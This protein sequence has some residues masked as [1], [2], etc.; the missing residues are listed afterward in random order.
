MSSTYSI[1]LIRPYLPPETKAMVADVLDSGY[2]T[3]GPITTELEKAVAAFVGVPHAVAAT[4]A[5]TGLELAL[6]AVGIGPGDEVIVPDY[7]FPATADVV[8]IV[9][10]D[11]V[12]VDIDPDTMLIDA[13]AMAAAVTERTR[14]VVPVSQFGNPL[15]YAHFEALRRAG[16]LIIE[17]AACALGAEHAGHKVGYDADVA[18]FSL[19]PRKFITTGEG[20][21]VVTGNPAWAAA[22]RSYKQF[23]AASR[24]SRPDTCFERI[25][26]NC[27]LSNILA[28]VGLAQ[29][30]R[31]D[32][33]LDRRL[34]LAAEYDRLLGDVSSV[35][36]PT[37][38]AGGVHSRQTYCVFVDRRDEVMATLRAMGIEVQIGSYALHRHPAFAPSAH[39]R[40]CGPFP[41]SVC[42]FER[43]LAL[44]LYHEMTASDQA[45]VVRELSA[46]VDAVRQ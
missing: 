41:G 43:C 28:A 9:G 20:G 22:L 25:G 39:V 37:A 12:L 15:D 13:A 8:R 30:L 45:A 5:T 4:S 36:L 10:A 26:T 29:M 7:T 11:V 40:R 44:P 14:A 1:P 2:L 34:A 33:L 21:I 24:E 16:I 6:R 19:H 27:K 3:E 31:V 23:G 42:A 32:E 38:T 35:A 17:D 18:V 46:V